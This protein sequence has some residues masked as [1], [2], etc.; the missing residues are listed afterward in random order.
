MFYIVAFSLG[1]PPRP[2]LMDL[3]KSL[4]SE[5]V[6]EDHGSMEGVILDLEPYNETMDT[7]RTTTILLDSLN[8]TILD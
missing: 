4:G 6:V 5:T 7:K 1:I 3:S 2:L 8:K